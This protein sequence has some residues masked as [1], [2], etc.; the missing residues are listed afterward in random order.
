[1]AH[2]NCTS[3]YWLGNVH[4]AGFFNDAMLALLCVNKILTYLIY[5]V[6]VSCLLKSTWRKWN[7]VRHCIETIP[8]SC[9]PMVDGQFQDPKSRSHQHL[10]DWTHRGRI[11]INTSHGISS[12]V[13]SYENIGTRHIKWWYY[14][15]IAAAHWRTVHFGTP[16]VGPIHN[17]NIGPINEGLISIPAMECHP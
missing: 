9:G 2:F 5:C 8:N 10:K 1:M 4:A 17:P 12:I 6:A 13:S 15:Q 7:N 16:R 14:Y 3:V 11:D